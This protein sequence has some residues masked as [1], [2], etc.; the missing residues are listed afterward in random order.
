MRVSK[1]NDSRTVVMATPTIS[2]IPSNQAN[3]LLQHQCYLRTHVQSKRDENLHDETPSSGNPSAPTSCEKWPRCWKDTRP[4]ITLKQTSVVT[5]KRGNKMITRSPKQNIPIRS[6]TYWTMLT[7]LPYV[8]ALKLKHMPDCDDI[9]MPA[10]RSS[11]SA[12]AHRHV[13]N[14]PWIYWQMKIWPTKWRSKV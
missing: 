11:A 4:Y 5:P 1:I 7:V 3:H 9:D 8:T 6:I 10:F 13:Q 14:R 2:N 12:G